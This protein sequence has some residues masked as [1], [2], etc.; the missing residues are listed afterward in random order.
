LKEIKDNGMA[1]HGTPV[2]QQ[3]RSSEPQQLFC[4]IRTVHST[5]FNQ[6]H[7]RHSI[8]Q[9]IQPTPL[10]RRQFCSASLFGMVQW[11]YSISPAAMQSL[12]PSANPITFKRLALWTDGMDTL[13]FQLCLFRYL[14]VAIYC[15][16]SL[17]LVDQ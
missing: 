13:R 14:T 11:K 10:D 5:S 1:W 9:S 15:S 2:V 3:E 17:L 4:D 8:V 12:D 7:R 16:S 6:C